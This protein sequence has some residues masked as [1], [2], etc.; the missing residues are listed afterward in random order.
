MEEIKINKVRCIISANADLRFLT[1]N[2]T[3]DVVAEDERAYGI[4]DDEENGV[5]FY[6]K[7]LF[8]P[9]YTVDG[10]DYGYYLD[11]SAIAGY[12]AKKQPQ[13]TLE[14]EMESKLLLRNLNKYMNEIMLIKKLNPIYLT[15]TELLDTLNWK[16]GNEWEERTINKKDPLVK[17]FYERLKR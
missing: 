9:I 13:L 7:A 10:V 11:D 3:Y 1:K 8:E 5:Y 12:D 14:E 2:K 15:D 6:G 16:Y 4:V 17:E